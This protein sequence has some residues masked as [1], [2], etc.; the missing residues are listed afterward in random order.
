MPGSVDRANY[1]QIDIS[2]ND[3]IAGLGERKS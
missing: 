3:K 2:T 1:R